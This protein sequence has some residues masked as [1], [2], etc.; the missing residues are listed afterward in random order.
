VGT[1]DGVKHAFAAPLVLAL[2]ACG[3]GGAGG[4]PGASGTSASGIPNASPT[5]ASGITVAGSVVALPADAYGPAA[6]AGVTYASAD[7]TRTAPL[8]G[9]IVIV[10]PLPVTGATPPAQLPSGDVA[11]TSD[12]NGAFAATLA[13][14]PA[15]SSG[16]APF[17][18]PQN[19]VLAFAPPAT[20][21][22][23]E[24]FAAGMLP[25][26]R[27]MA[28][29][30]ALALRVSSASAAE[31]AALAAINADRA[32]HGA[33]ALIFDEAAEEAARLHAS[34]E[35]VAGYT[36]HYDARNVGPSSRYLA[37]GG[38]GLTGEALA[39]VAGAPAAAFANAE[40]AFMAEQSATPPGSHFLNLIDG[41]H[42]WAGLA[43][44]A[45]ASAPAFA[46][47]DYELVTPNGADAV[48]GSSGYPVSAPCPPGT[49]VNDS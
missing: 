40:S 11:V 9:A 2:A 1:G 12:A 21:Y 43:A 37:A 10:G 42:Q 26:H 29:S 6:I 33:G 14:A 48:V 39:L 20:G 7:A 18:I 31:A 27:F 49:T 44:I 15:P 45:D 24:A 38:I 13:V 3:G 23:V 28:A 47:V 19:D 36:C 5:P 35:S 32:A 30:A 4:A 22:Y 34:D 41:A 17:V 46:N 16:A 8:A 25:L